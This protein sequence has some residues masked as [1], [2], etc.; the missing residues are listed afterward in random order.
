MTRLAW[1]V[2]SATFLISLV[3][4]GCSLTGGTASVPLAAQQ[5]FVWPYFGE[6]RIA[7]SAV[8]DPASITSLYDAQDAQML[9][10]GLVTFSDTTLKP[11]PYAATYDVDAT[12]TVYTFHLKANL[13]FSDGTPLTASDYAYSINRALSPSLCTTSDLTTYGANGSNACHTGFNFTYLGDILGAAAFSNGQG[14]SSLI[15]A[16][17]DDSTKGLSVIDPLTLRIRLDR[18]IAYFLEAL[19]Y[20]AAYPVERSLVENPTYA[21]GK[22]VDHMDI[23]G[24]S[25][26]FK[27]AAYEH[28]AANDT[29]VMVPN[30]YWAQ[31]FGQH[32]TLQRVERPFISDQDTE[33]SNYKGGQYSYTDVPSD[34]YSQARGQGDF[35]EIPTLQTS[36]FGLNFDLPPFNN[37]SV[38]RAF[39]LA[40][41][42]QL[43][44]D[45]VE[46]GGALPSNHIVPAGMPG[47]D[48][49][50]VN[51]PP[52]ST[53]SL[54]GNQAAAQELIAAVRHTCAASAN[55]L[56]VP[57]ECAYVLPDPIT[58]KPKA[59]QFYCDGA[60]TPTDLAIAN[61][62]ATQWNNV[63]GLNVQV[64]SVDQSTLFNGLTNPSA[65]PI[66]E[67]GWSADYPDPQDW[68]SL[69]FKS[70][71]GVDASDVRNS[72][73]D[74]QMNHA[75]V[76]QNP[77]RRMAEYNKIEQEMVNLC[78]WIPFQQS[79]TAW[80][81]RLNVHGF[82]P[83]ELDELSGPDWTHVY[84]TT[85]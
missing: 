78:A 72:D 2:A 17:G 74:A 64:F 6:T 20:P 14:P 26:P 82:V 84:I 8:L 44:V 30:P 35:H 53:Q 24:A 62:A 77:T 12:G 16:H 36:Y 45:R 54:T 55:A 47:Y 42:K 10:A 75:D 69:Q 34:V 4:S 11:V 70:G 31:A 61:A 39:D 33:Y 48:P 40:L 76:D 58:G 41:N 65:F 38:R 67:V 68:L 27:I 28:G 22:W 37:L 60:S 32:L 1:L 18:P 85:Q 9:Y 21:G 57:P 51:P 56:Q 66:W 29:L 83:S 46:N 23:G 5:D 59:I 52:D 50:I 13:R 73:L 19:T 63:L 81:V 25:G 15:S 3:L 79:K 43:L 7:Y 71:S 49:A 80:R